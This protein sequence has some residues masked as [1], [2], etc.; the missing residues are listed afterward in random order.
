MGKLV[1]R[2]QGRLVGE[3]NLRLGD[4]K[5]GRKPT[6]DIVLADAG[7]SGEHALIQTVG[8]RSTIRD[9]DS[10]NGTF[11]ESKRIRK[12]ELRHGETIIIGEHSLLYREDIN[13]DLPPPGKRPATLMESSSQEK[14]AVL[15]SF[16][17]LLAVEGKDKGKRVPLVK[18]ETVFE[19][20][21]GRPWR[22]IRTPESYVVH[23]SAGPNEPRVNDK[24]L[25]PGGHLLE[26][27]DL[28]RVAGT[29][30]RFF[31]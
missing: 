4:M 24:P 21:E 17:H 27:G 5:I 22:I 6:C 18:E 25:P 12:H 7:V 19:N 11:V 23:G 15:T 31:K 1:I 13:L 9:L 14:T 2:Y 10:T 16:G 28:I 3:V 8:T 30:Y 26:N 20:P 29:T